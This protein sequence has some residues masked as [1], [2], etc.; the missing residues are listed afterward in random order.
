MPYRAVIDWESGEIS[1]HTNHLGNNKC[2]AT[3]A[4]KVLMRGARRG[5]STSKEDRPM[6]I[7]LFLESRHEHVY[8]DTYVRDKGWESDN[9]PFVGRLAE[10]RLT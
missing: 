3:E 4:V 10:C 2:Y 6:R 7:S 1:E 5:R 8:V 9:N